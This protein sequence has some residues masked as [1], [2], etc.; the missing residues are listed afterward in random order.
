MSAKIRIRTYACVGP[1]ADNTEFRVDDI[2]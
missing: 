2:I 1:R